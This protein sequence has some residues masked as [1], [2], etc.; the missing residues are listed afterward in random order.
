MCLNLVA[1]S[2]KMRKQGHQGVAMKPV[3]C[4]LCRAVTLKKM[5]FLFQNQRTFG[6]WCKTRTKNRDFKK[7]RDIKKPEAKLLSYDYLYNF[8]LTI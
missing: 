3:K 4:M 2:E 5:F 1:E 7:N 8:S 6:Q